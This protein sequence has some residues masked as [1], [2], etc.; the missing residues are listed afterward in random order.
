VIRS[1]LTKIGSVEWG[2]EWGYL[3]SRAKVLD[4]VNRMRVNKRDRYLQAWDSVIR[5]VKRYP[6][7]F[8]R[9]RTRIFDLLKGRP[10]I[11]ETVK[12]QIKQI[13]DEHIGKNT[14]LAIDQN[15]D[16]RLFLTG[17][18]IDYF[19]PREIDTWCGDM[20]KLN[21]PIPRRRWPIG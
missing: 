16:A 18:V 6:Q 4:A 20:F 17:I 1:K 5:D 2:F 10:E 21:S 12:D 11:A 19:G 8:S 14:P 7:Y 13:E 3:K 15:E 9:L